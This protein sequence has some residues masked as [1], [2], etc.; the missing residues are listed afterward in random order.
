MTN[1][2]ET[3]RFFVIETNPETRTQ[4]C[5]AVKTTLADAIRRMNAEK[6]AF[7]G[8]WFSIEEN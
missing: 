5:V 2:T 3:S 7:P 8:M 1:A 6:E 4:N